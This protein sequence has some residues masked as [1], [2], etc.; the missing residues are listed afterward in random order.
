[1][2]KHARLAAIWG[3]NA[4]LDSSG[5]FITLC[6][7]FT[8]MMITAHVYQNKWYA[9]YRSIR[10]LRENRLF[11]RKSNKIDEFRI[12]ADLAEI[13]CEIKRALIRLLNKRN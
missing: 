11:K 10:T 13:K 2:R 12:V 1:M 7:S 9:D 3:L 4:A 6:T 5:D 8:N